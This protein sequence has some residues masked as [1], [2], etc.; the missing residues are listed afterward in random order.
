MENPVCAS[1]ECPAYTHAYFHKCELFDK[2]EVCIDCVRD[3]PLEEFVSN[4]KKRTNKEITAE[5]I[6]NICKDGAHL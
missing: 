3:T 6:K 2:K 4:V 5:D 1:C